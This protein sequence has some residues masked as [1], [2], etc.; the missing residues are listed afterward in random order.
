MYPMRTSVA[1]SGHRGMRAAFV[2]HGK[3]S[4]AFLVL[5]SGFYFLHPLDFAPRLAVVPFEKII[6]GI[7][8]ITFIA[9]A[10]KQRGA[11]RFAPE[12]KLLILFFGLLCLSIPFAYW[13]GG[14][15]NAVFGDYAKAII[16]AIVAMVVTNSLARLRTLLFVQAG[17]AATMATVAIVLRQMYA[18]RLQIGSSIYGNPNDLALAIALNLPICL[19]F[20]LMTRNLL[21]KIIWGI[22]VFAMLYALLLTYSRG[23]FLAATL[24]IALWVWEFGVRRRRFSLVFLSLLCSLVLL[25]AVPTRYGTRLESIF[26]PKADPTDHGS[27]LARRQLLIEGLAIAGKHP[28]FGIGIGNFEIFSSWHGTHNTY[29]QIASEAG[30]PAFILFVLILRRS[31]L[32]LRIRHKLSGSS[33]DRQLR[34]LASGL[35]AS[36]GAYILGACFTDTASFSYVYL[37]LSYTAVLHNLCIARAAENC[38]PMS[39]DT[40]GQDIASTQEAG[41]SMVAVTKL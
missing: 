33:A 22:G 18:D 19:V 9:S 15:F 38:R 30:L 2:S 40:D 26:A 37:L 20:S 27:S 3:V 8:I 16:I 28:L 13:R 25:M 14:S 6:G 5:F 23:G 34:L 39:I 32:N 12:V 1:S 7:A 36:L 17:A 4:F 10:L 11:I 35:K 31:F 24:G 21:K 41:L 29:T